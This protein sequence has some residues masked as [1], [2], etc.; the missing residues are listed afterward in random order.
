MKPKAYDAQSHRSLHLMKKPSVPCRLG[1]IKIAQSEKLEH[2]C[3]GF[4][5]FG[6]KRENSSET[7]NDF[8]HCN[9]SAKRIIGKSV[10]TPEQQQNQNDIFLNVCQFWHLG[11]F[12]SK[13]NLG[14]K[15]N[16]SIICCTCVLKANAI[17]IVSS[18]VKL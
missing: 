8:C 10:I 16:L 2:A 5:G 1:Y 7:Q 18:N 6:A 17:K 4:E 12:I 15:P 3:A 13:G 11:I 9:S 14:S